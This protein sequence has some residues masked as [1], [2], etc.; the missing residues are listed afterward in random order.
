[1]AK[2]KK[3]KKAQKKVRGPAPARPSR[4][5]AK[6]AQSKAHVAP[7]P[8]PQGAQPWTLQRATPW[9][10]ALL[11][12]LLY[13]VTLAFGY[14]LDDT[15]VIVENA[16]VQHGISGIGLILESAY[17]KGYALGTPT[18]YRPLSL[19]TFAVE[20]TIWASPVLHHSTQVLLYGLSAVLVYR[21]GAA[22]AGPRVALLAALLWVVHPVHTEVV[23]NIKS[24]DELLAFVLGASTLLLAHRG[25]LGWAALA[26]AGAALCKESV[27][28]FVLVLPAMLWMTRSD[29]G[30]SWVTLPGAAL[31]FFARLSATGTLLPKTPSHM[32][33]PTHNVLLAATGPVEHL[34]TVLSF[35][36]RYTQLLLMPIELVYDYSIGQIPLVGLLDPYALVGAAVLAGL[37][38]LVLWKRRGP[39]AFGAAYLLLTYAVVSNALLQISGS[40]MAERY[41]F[42]PSFGL[43]LLL[44]L[45]LAR[46]PQKLGWVLVGLLTLVGG[47][48]VAERLPDWQSDAV[49]FAADMATAPGNPR[50]AAH[51]AHARRAAPQDTTAALLERSLALHATDPQRYRHAGTQASMDLC[52]L[53]MA[54]GQL[55]RAAQR[56]EQALE[57]DPSSFRAAFHLGEVRYAQARYADSARAYVRAVVTKEGSPLAPADPTPLSTYTL[58]LALSQL[59]AGDL[60]GARRNFQRTLDA[61]AEQAKAWAG[62]ALVAERQGRGAD[63]A[64]AWEKARAIDPSL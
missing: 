37:V 59:Q 50:V 43:C 22:L 13:G 12:V 44:G 53:Y 46:L 49:L 10:L 48:R 61:K 63:A 36:G 38:G 54:D 62:L 16:H 27:L 8:P 3:K 20:Q 18:F 41:L 55:D 34:G 21:L 2:T 42:T 56:C 17:W 39:V 52:R 64:A 29:L 19:I 60:Y 11:A 26:F 31:Y 23:A 4:A 5:P 15:A 9:L 35:A 51:F 47:L 30:R 1:M 7:G 45:G 25:R 40:T 14:T 6:R 32:L 28:T 57:I 58:N 33:E 24:R